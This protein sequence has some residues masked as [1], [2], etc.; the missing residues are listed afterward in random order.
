MLFLFFKWGTQWLNYFK[1][2]CIIPKISQKCFF[3]QKKNRLSVQIIRYQS[4]FDDY[5]EITD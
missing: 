2:L 5:C 1:K 4:E 3:F